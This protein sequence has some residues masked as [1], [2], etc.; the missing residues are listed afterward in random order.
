MVS[1]ATSYGLKFDE[2]YSSIKFELDNTSISDKNE[3]TEKYTCQAD[4]I[5]KMGDNK[6][7]APITYTSELVNDGEKHLV[8]VYG[9]DEEKQGELLMSVMS[10][11]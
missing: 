2:D 7:E 8:R 1:M 4:L 5:S 3:K 6:F 9:L 10:S 11:K